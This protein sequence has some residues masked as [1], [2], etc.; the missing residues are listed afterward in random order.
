[1]GI[2][3]SHISGKNCLSIFS[4]LLIMGAVC[5]TT[6]SPV[7]AEYGYTQ[8][9]MGSPDWLE[10]K[11]NASMEPDLYKQMQ[12]GSEAI[13][14]TYTLINEG[15]DLLRGGDYNEAI[16][17]FKW[18]IDA[19][20]EMF[21][22]WLGHGMALEGLK[23]YQSSLD[24]YEAAIGL[25]KSN[26]NAWIPYA[27]KARALLELQKYQESV[28]AFTLAIDKYGKS[29]SENKTDLENLNAG[30]AD[31]KEKLGTKTA[32]NVATNSS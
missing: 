8:K 24:S 26:K 20:S 14:S 1:M 2:L 11:A 13:N 32:A 18:A 22:A 25:A 30:L 31:A 5:I 10:E 27:G 15:K 16:S 23:R 4:I 29:G 28:S 3:S 6:I 7:S 9:W 19:D 17:D 12:K 21:D